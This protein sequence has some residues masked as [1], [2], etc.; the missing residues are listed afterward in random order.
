MW[1]RVPPP[2]LPRKGLLWLCE[3]L[4]G[5]M[6]RELRNEKYPFNCTDFASPNLRIYIIMLALRIG[7][8]AMI[9]LPLLIAK[10]HS[11]HLTRRDLPQL[12]LLVLAGFVVNN[13]LEYGGLA[14]TTAA[15]VSLLITS[16][17]IFTALLACW[18]LR[19]K[20]KRTTGGSSG[21]WIAGDVSHY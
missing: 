16:E 12:A 4:K 1:V 17:S 6:R 7:I 5:N 10:R 9:L 18:L 19:E 15:D 11:L 14:L 3:R 13:L 20:F 8:A 2:S 21:D